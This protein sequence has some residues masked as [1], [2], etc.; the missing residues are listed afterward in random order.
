M[1]LEQPSNEAQGA[2]KKKV[3]RLP[4]QGPCV[5]T[6]C[7]HIGEKCVTRSAINGQFVCVKCGLRTGE[8][9]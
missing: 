9:K 6:Y 8:K 5:P 1:T 3:E 7:R 2:T 4:D